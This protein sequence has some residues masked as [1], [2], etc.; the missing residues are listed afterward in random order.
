MNPCSRN[1]R[2]IGALWLTLLTACGGGG[3]AG[4]STPPPV[5]TSFSLAAGYQ[6]RIVNGTSENFAL[7]GSCTG[8]ATITTSAAVPSVFEGVAGV[9]ADQVSTATLNNCS[10]SSSSSTGT[11]Y[12]NSSYANLGLAVFNGEYASFAAPPTALPASVRIG[13]TGTVVTLNSYSDGSKSTQTGTRVISY[14][15]EADGSSTTTS[16]VNITTRS[17]NTSSQLLST[18]QSRYRMAE[19]G[20]LT[21]LTIEIQFSTT[22]TLRLVYTRL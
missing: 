20:A 16:I 18:Q 5:T 12:F 10:P 15:I 6:A 11:T 13:D 17:F 9:S 19:N 8:T 21:L 1:L 7:S 4:S 2:A 3:D 14:V 22:S